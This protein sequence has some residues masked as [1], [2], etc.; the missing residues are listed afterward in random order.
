MKVYESARLQKL[1]IIKLKRD[2]CILD[3]NEKHI[4]EEKKYHVYLKIE[5]KRDDTRK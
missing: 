2:I 1:Y 4:P 3:T 5:T